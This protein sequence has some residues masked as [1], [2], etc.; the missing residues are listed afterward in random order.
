MN[1]PNTSDKG[2]GLNGQRWI[3]LDKTYVAH[4]SIDIKNTV[5]QKESVIISNA[6]NIAWLR[7]TGMQGPC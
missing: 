1:F 2:H 6:M 5:S 7:S 4:D 3:R